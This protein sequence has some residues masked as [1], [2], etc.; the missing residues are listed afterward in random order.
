MKGN[1]RGKMTSISEKMPMH[2]EMS[3]SMMGKMPNMPMK[4]SMHTKEMDKGMKKK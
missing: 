4:M 3:K 2:A 1:T